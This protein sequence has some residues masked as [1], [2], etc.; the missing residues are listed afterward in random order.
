MSTFTQ[1][2]PVSATWATLVS[3]PVIPA[4]TDFVMTASIT[5]SPGNY[6]NTSNQVAVR[7]YRQV[8]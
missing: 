3:Q 4:D 1:V 7:I 6:Y 8:V 2:F 5:S